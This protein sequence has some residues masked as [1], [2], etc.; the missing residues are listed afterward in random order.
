[1]GTERTEAIKEWSDMNSEDYTENTYLLLVEKNYPY[2]Y[3]TTPFKN[4]SG[5]KFCS[6]VCSE[7]GDYLI[8]GIMPK[9][10]FSNTSG[11]I[12][13][14]KQRLQLIELNRAIDFLLKKGY[15]LIDFDVD[16]LRKIVIDRIIRVTENINIRQNKNK[17]NSIENE[18]QGNISFQKDNIFINIFDNSSEN[19]FGINREECFEDKRVLYRSRTIYFYEQY[20]GD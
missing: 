10:Y 1:M 4:I 5:H 16:N 17:F 3:F 13:F 2:R 8:L 14:E 18:M 11:V 19:Y 15:A 9:E 12:N 20:I 7:Y 6:E